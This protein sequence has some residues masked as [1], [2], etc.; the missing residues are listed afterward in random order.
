MA[1]R[2]FHMNSVYKR[3]LKLQY[4]IR[5]HYQFY[6]LSTLFDIVRSA[7]DRAILFNFSQG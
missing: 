2:G 1:Q 5:N 6:L 4:L 7:I 3:N